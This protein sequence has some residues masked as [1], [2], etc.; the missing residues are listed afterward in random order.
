ME[1]T[2]NTFG[3]GDLHT[4]PR[5]GLQQ[6]DTRPLSIYNKLIIRHSENA[7]HFKRGF[8]NHEC[9][10]KSLILTNLL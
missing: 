10:A 2:N 3:Y 9:L 6:A 1:L 4:L 7:C 8:K 5:P